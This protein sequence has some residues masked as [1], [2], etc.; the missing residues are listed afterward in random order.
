MRF[1]KEHPMPHFILYGT[2]GCH[3]CELA[4]AQLAALMAQLSVAIEIECI[5]IAEGDN[6]D[7]LIERYGVRIPVLRRQRDQS[8]LGWPFADAQMLEFLQ[9]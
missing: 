4:E 6:S 2:L 5:D 8:E 7:E 1:F 9:G 3:L